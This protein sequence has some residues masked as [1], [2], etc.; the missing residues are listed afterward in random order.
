MTGAQIDRERRKERARD[1]RLSPAQYEQWLALLRTLSLRR[2]S[3]KCAM[4]FAYDH[5]LCAEDVVS[6]VVK[7]LVWPSSVSLS[8]ASLCALSECS[9]PHAAVQ[10][11]TLYLFSDLLHNSASPIQ[12]ATH[13]KLA[14]CDALPLVFALLGESVRRAQGRMS[15]FQVR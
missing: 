7:K 12:H 2:E 14:V 11:A 4:G 15:A 10:I 13:Y 5:V 8:P 1:A 9:L 3:V 6:T